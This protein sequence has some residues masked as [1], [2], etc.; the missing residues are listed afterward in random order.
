[1]ITVDFKRLKLKPGS[2]I[3]DVGCGQGRH[4]CEA[5]CQP[6][7]TAV[8]LD[9]NPSDVAQ[10]RGML[11]A[12][13]DAGMGGGGT[14][15]VFSGDCTCLPFENDFFDAVICSEVLEHIPNNK[16]AAAELVRVLKPTGVL[17]VSVPRYTPEVICWTLSEQYYNTPGGH[18]RIYTRKSLLKLIEGVGMKY[19]GGHFAHSL[20]TPYWW[21]KCAMSLDNEDARAVRLYHRFLVWDIMKKPW[22]TRALDKLLNPF[23]GKSCVYYF[24]RP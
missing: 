14:W 2:R 13:D 5:Y 15:Q 23:I 18:I 11:C 9:L 10:T 16:K 7:I 17:A 3:L 8:G 12:M 4:T 19:R 6:G 1:M 22:L 20:H 21:L 24:T